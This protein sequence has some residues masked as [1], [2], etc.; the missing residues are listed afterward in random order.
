M[1][2]FVNFF[3]FKRFSFIEGYIG[4]NIMVF[5]FV[6]RREKKNNFTTT[7]NCRQDFKFPIIIG[8]NTLQVAVVTTLKSVILNRFK[9]R[10]GLPLSNGGTDDLEI[11]KWA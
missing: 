8:Q 1:F 10:S 5:S 6:L 2:C 3:V 7:S 4:K 9:V 11:V